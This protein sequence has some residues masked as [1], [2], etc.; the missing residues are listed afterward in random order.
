MQGCSDRRVAPG[1]RR[2]RAAAA[3]ASSWEDYPPLLRRRH[4]VLTGQGLG[5]AMPPCPDGA[6]YG[7]LGLRSAGRRWR[8]PRRPHRPG[9]GD[10]P[11]RPARTVQDAGGP[12][13][14][15]RLAGVGDPPPSPARV[16]D[17]HCRPARSVQDTGDSD[18]GRRLR[19]RRPHQ[20][21]PGPAMPPARTVLLPKVGPPPA[22]SDSGR[23]AGPRGH[24]LPPAA[25]RRVSR[26]NLTALQSTGQ[27][28]NFGGRWQTCKGHAPTYSLYTSGGH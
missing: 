24:R 20:S 19:T 5:L 27:P 16:G 11:C 26:R 1:I 8:R 14:S 7:R 2:T 4:A 3:G 22:D 23:T 28:A 17:W 9:P 21:G 12:D 25:N 6:A 10:W 13:W 18:R 15:P